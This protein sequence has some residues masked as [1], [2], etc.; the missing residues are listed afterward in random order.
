YGDGSNLSD[1]DIEALAALTDG[2][3]MLNAEQAQRE[4]QAAARAEK[5]AELAARVRGKGEEDAD[6]AEAPEDGEGED[7]EAPATAEEESEDG[8]GD[9]EEQPQEQREPEVIAAS[10]RRGPVRV[11]LSGRA[12]RGHTP[13]EENRGATGVRSVM[14][15]N[16]APGLRDGQGI[17][18]M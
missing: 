2:I 13:P 17:D 12:R 16:D 5:A 14:F 1:Q 4:E 8:E 3:E 10:G 9:G 18:F 7:A 11:N 15:A 6:S